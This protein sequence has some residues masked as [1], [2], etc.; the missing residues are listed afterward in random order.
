MLSFKAEPPRMAQERNLD[1]LRR[2]NRLWF[3]APPIILAKW[4]VANNGREDTG[5]GQ[6]FGKILALLGEF[7]V[8]FG[9]LISFSAN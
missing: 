1:H 2:K 3:Y 6:R 7:I 4:D 8:L 5:G 9:E